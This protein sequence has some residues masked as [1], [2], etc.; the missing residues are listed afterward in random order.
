MNR[1]Q[2]RVDAI[3]AE[4]ARIRTLTLSAAAGGPLPGFSAG[5]HL[6]LAIPGVAEARCYSL[7]GLGASASA[8]SAAFAR[9]ACYR[10]G[11]RLEDA[12]RGGSRHLHQLGVGALIEASGPVNDFPLH[13]A[14]AGEGPVVL[15]A[16]GIGIT[17]IASMAAALQAAGRPYVLHYSGRSRRELAYLPALQALAGDALRLYADD[18]PAHRLALDALLD[19]IAANQ[20]L[21]ACGPQG[22]IDALI[23]GTRA[24]AWAAGR[25]H[26]E[27]FTTAAP[28]AGDTPFELEL[29]QSGLRFTVAAD[30]TIL[31]AMEAHGYA[32]LYDCKR[33]ECGVCVAAVLDGVP[34]HRDYC[35]SDAEKAAGRHI[36]LCVSRARSPRL[37]LDL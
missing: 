6:K 33:G 30:Q 36:Q 10:L 29:R 28:Q 4:T 13:P 17:P 23:A 2:L 24:R 22:L 27:L 8:G 5:A 26:F 18:E 32:P 3:T 11:V 12:S 9:P 37:V 34:E 16:G 19:G 25:L 31:E 14:E 1:L 35:L 7:L 15:L 20:H 21:Y